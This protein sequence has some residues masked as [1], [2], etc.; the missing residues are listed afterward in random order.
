[1]APKTLGLSLPLIF[2]TLG[3]ESDFLWQETWGRIE[4]SSAPHVLVEERGVLEA[5][6][7]LGWEIH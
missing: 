4:L 7:L 6:I 1:M 5:R 2:W 3:K